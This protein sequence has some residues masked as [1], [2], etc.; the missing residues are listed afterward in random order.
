MN[1]FENPSGMDANAG[2]EELRAKLQAL[3]VFVALAL[4]MMIGFSFCADYF[5]N[6]QIEALNA[7]TAQFQMVVDNFPQAAANDFVK[8]LRDYA[9]TH[10]DFKP[11]TMKYAGL[12][13]QQPAPKK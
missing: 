6:R 10:P 1:E 2:I 7:E 5:L 11:I 4:V 8:H 3:Q 13:G 9:A 12:F